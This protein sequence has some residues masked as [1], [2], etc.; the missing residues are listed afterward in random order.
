MSHS[1]GIPEPLTG[2]TEEIRAVMSRKIIDMHQHLAAESDTE[3][4]A[5]EYERAGV[6][7]AV[8]LGIQSRRWPE[9]NDVVLS[10]S[11]RMP[12]L[13]VPFVGFDLDALVPD[14]L[15]RSR[16]QGFCGVKFIAPDRPYNHPGYMPVYERALEL[17]LPVLFHLGI[18]TNQP[19]WA[20]VDSNNMR[21]IYLDHIARQLPEL[22][23][24]GAH[25][26]NPW[27]EEATMG[28]RWNTNLFY[29]LSGSTLK[30]KRPSFLSDL[31]WWSD[32]SKPYTSPDRTSAWEKIVFGS[33]VAPS[34]V[35]DVI[36]DYESLIT[37]LE[38]S[39]D[40]AE[41]IWYGTGARILGIE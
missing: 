34:L 16:D 24:V 2:V 3:L 26:G 7:K 33:D 36:A 41:R 25:L 27:Y 23:I 15:S 6:V 4:L 20:D 11:R 38:L 17:Q 37:S 19:A 21:P 39:P 12:E 18:V 13:F 1:G 28:C 9:N 40:L 10:A 14:D 31:L 30:K 22:T 8:L 5:A 29:D 32:D 35:S